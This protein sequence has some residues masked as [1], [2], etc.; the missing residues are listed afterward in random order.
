MREIFDISRPIWIEFH[1]GN[2]SKN[3]SVAMS[4]GGSG[5]HNAQMRL[6]VLSACTVPSVC[7]IRYNRPAYKA[8]GDC[9]VR[10]NWRKE[11]RTVPV[12]VAEIL[13]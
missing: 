11:G 10:H 7:T 8:A 13:H 5:S 1:K 6:L 2:V 4:V 9:C 12:G 3:Y